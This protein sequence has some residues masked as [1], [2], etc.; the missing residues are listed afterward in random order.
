MVFESQVSING[1]RDHQDPNYRTVAPGT[2]AGV[3]G[4]MN[5]AADRTIRDR[6]GPD[7]DTEGSK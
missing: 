4:D 7:Q 2:L 6:V 3:A 5:V 1:N